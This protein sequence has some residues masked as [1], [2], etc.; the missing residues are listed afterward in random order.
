MDRK[1]TVAIVAKTFSGN[2]K[3]G[4]SSTTQ[5]A[6]TAMHLL[7]TVIKCILEFTDMKNPEMR[8]KME[9]LNKYSV[10]T[11]VPLAMPGDCRVCAK[12]L[13]SFTLTRATDSSTEASEYHKT[14]QVITI[15]QCASVC[16]SNRVRPV[17][18]AQVSHMY[19]GAF[20]ALA[21]EK[22]FL[23]FINNTE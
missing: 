23:P 3:Y 4:S 14:A 6:R 18:Q 21:E 20:C 7:M 9:R 1:V 13:H 12:F 2:E 8:L 5:T 19:T 15:H 22:T 17:Q 10:E 11:L 16:G